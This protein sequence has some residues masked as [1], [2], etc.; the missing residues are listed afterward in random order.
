MKFEEDD[1]RAIVTKHFPNARL[2]DASRLTGGVSADVFK[3]VIEHK[4]GVDGVVLRIHGDTHSG[5][6]A[7]LEY[8]L[9][10]SL[11]TA[12]VSV[13]AP[14]AVDVSQEDIPAAYLLLAYIE[15]VTAIA[16][17]FAPI[18]IKQMA[19]TLFN[20][21]DSQLEGLPQLPLR[22]EPLP[23]LFDYLPEGPE[24]QPV[25]ESLDKIQSEFTGT[26][27]LLHGDFWPENIMWRAERI[28][29]ILDWEDAAIGDPLADVAG[30]FL[31]L[32]YVYGLDGSELFLNEYIRLS[33]WIDLRRLSLWKIYVTA[34]AQKYMGRWG[35][36]VEKE[37]HMRATALTTLREAGE[38]LQQQ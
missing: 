16:D 6:P 28:V 19:H 26:P 11:L 33:G 2:V 4:S 8:D 25:K 31:E 35:L 34:A 32:R 7:L 13:A 21:H 3:L 30:C 20:L 37:V 9:L 1:F 14:I 18:A 23:E 36:P 29:A 27:R 17:D 38:F 22:L 15:G 10:N 24:W 5:H 12:G